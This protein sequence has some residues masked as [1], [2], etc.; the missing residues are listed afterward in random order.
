MDGGTPLRGFNQI[1]DRS[2]AKALLDI[3]TDSGGD[4][5]IRIEA[6]KILGLYHGEYDDAFIK[7]ALVQIINHDAIEDDSLIVNCINTLALLTVNEKEIAFALSI[8]QGDAYIL[9]K[10]AAFSLICQ[11]KQHSAALAALKVLL[12][13][14]DF[15]RHAKRELT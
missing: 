4:D 9:F 11:N 8:I 14:S 7:E 6:V 12:K 15:G 5:D 13:D 1:L 10:H 2:S 3:A